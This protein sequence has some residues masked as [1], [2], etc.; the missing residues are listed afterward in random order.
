MAHSPESRL[1]LD[2]AWVMDETT[3]AT[4]PLQEAR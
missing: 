1:D 2:E 3:R 4:G